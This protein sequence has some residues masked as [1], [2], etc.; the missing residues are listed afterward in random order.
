MHNI[1]LLTRRL[2]IIS[3][4]V[5]MFLISFNQ[6][7]AQGTWIPVA[8]TS[9]NK[10]YGVMLL[11]TDGRVL[12]KSDWDMANSFSC[13]CLGDP[14]NT[15]NMLTPDIHG[16]YV[17]GTWSVVAPMAD[18][19]VF[20]ASQ[21]LRDGRMY[22]AGGEYGSGRATA[23]IYNP[24]SDVWTPAPLIPGDTILDGNSQLLPDGRV[25]QAIA[26][27]SATRTCI[28]NP[29][30]NTFSA[31]PSVLNFH[32]ETAWLLL[33][34]NSILFADRSFGALAPTAER[35]I[36]ALGSWTSDAAPPLTLYDYATA[37]TGSAQLLPDGRGVFFGGSGNTLYYTPSGST[38]PGNWTVGPHMPSGLGAPDGPTATMVNGKILC[39]LSDT[40]TNAVWFPSP[41]YFY[42]FDYLA[43][44]WTKISSPVGGDTLT[45][46]CAIN[47]MLTLPD[48]NIMFASFG[49]EQ[50][51]LFKPTGTALVAG[52]PK[53]DNIF[54][55][56][57]TKY[58]AVG[59]LFNGISQGANYNDE[60]QN[61]TNYPLVRL[62]YGTN[63]YYAR[64]YNWNST[65]VMRGN[66]AD[67]TYFDLPGSL[68]SG[69]YQLEVVANGNPSVSRTFYTCG[70]IEVPTV[71]MHNNGLSITP[72][73]AKSA[74]SLVFNA[75][76]ACPFTVRLTDLTGRIL[77][78]ET[79]NTIEGE[80][81]YDLHTHGLSK[82]V[83][84]ISVSMADGVMNEKVVVE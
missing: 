40:C 55:I 1:N 21:I 12:V 82:G 25:L 60:W 41:N 5:L 35:Y 48:G 72:N 18:T 23:E 81:T 43:G 13:T 3:T 36:P 75:G 70:Q 24:V 76:R 54:K 42:V 84:M 59:K 26:K 19:R 16:S 39:S 64:T 52:K 73:P 22:V 63:V 27:G 31:G 6:L 67:T 51:Y 66:A 78:E 71:N 14:G 32:S 56:T 11:L 28:Y 29:V 83:Y 74:T 49:L 65:G 17:N 62:T 15:W 37:E 8:N 69:T 44:T 4:C 79:G 10:N 33:K 34:D 68:P 77:L 47:N 50:Y 2:C 80:N 38:S 20:F 9:P 7:L 61:P 46:S 45:G 58:M 57:C 53:I 30:T